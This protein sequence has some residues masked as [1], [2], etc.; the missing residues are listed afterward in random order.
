MS[1]TLDKD[2]LE[3]IKKVAAEIAK[4]AT[5]EIEPMTSLRGVHPTMFMPPLANTL[6]DGLKH[7]ISLHPR[8][9]RACIIIEGS[10]HLNENPITDD[11][12]D[13][14]EILVSFGIHQEGEEIPQFINFGLSPENDLSNL[15]GLYSAVSIMEEHLRGYLD[16]R[17]NPDGSEI[18]GGE[19]Q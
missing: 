7:L 9:L 3:A 10:S 13:E 19:G 17:L 14:G 15:A 12:V 1:Y 5:Q 8:I 2:S 4:M 11:N 6:V 18:T 16:G